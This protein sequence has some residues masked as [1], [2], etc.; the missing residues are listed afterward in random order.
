MRYGSTLALAC[1]LT[2][3][4]P[5]TL[6][7]QEARS[8]S[9]NAVCTAIVKVIIDGAHHNAKV[10]CK[11]ALV[12][13]E[14]GPE[15]LAIT[16]PASWGFFRQFGLT[17]FSA[18]LRDFDMIS[19]KADMRFRNVGVQ[20]RTVLSTLAWDQS[21]PSTTG[22]KMYKYKKTVGD[23]DK[24][25]APIFA[26]ATSLTV[27]GETHSVKIDDRLYEIWGY[28]DYITRTF[29]MVARVEGEQ[30][31]IS[32][33]ITLQLTGPLPRKAQP[34]PP[35]PPPPPPPPGPTFAARN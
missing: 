11:D 28:V 14:V 1:M 16:G 18:R 19:S 10:L 7:A 20:L 8:Y 25:D 24:V 12:E 35:M 32:N 26:A 6:P 15:E 9:V 21:A 3:F 4:A 30:D 17:R 22:D 29:S 23:E 33:D 34:I 5:T 13:F 2:V 27:D 31:G